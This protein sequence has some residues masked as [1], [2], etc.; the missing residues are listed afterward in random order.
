MSASP[1][2]PNTQRISSRNALLSERAIYHCLVQKTVDTARANVQCAIQYDQIH[3]INKPQKK[4]LFLDRY[5]P[6]VKRNRPR[7]SSVGGKSTQSRRQQETRSG[8]N[9]DFL[10]HLHSP[11]NWNELTEVHRTVP[12]EKYQHKHDHTQF[13]T[14]HIVTFHDRVM[15]TTYLNIACRVTSKVYIYIS[16]D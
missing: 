15:L 16:F 2:S 9:I 14:V 11:L 5:R 4:A 3:K 10:Q 1:P 13:P 6:D 7:N 12:L 8:A